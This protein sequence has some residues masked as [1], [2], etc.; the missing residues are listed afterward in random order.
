MTMRRFAPVMVT[1]VFA[2]SAGSSARAEPQVVI[3]TQARSASR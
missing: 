1:F 3:E 2:A